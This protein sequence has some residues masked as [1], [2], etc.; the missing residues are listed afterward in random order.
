MQDSLTYISRI[1]FPPTRSPDMRP[2]VGTPGRK[3]TVSQTRC[4]CGCELTSE[5]DCDAKLVTEAPQVVSVWVERKKCLVSGER[6]WASDNWRETCVF[7]FDN[8]LLVDVS[9]LYKCRA[10]FIGGTPIQIFLCAHLEPL[11][12][13]SLWLLENPVFGPSIIDKSSRFFV[14]LTNAF[15]AVLAL[16]DFAFE[17]RCFQWGSHPDILTADGCVKMQVNQMTPKLAAASR[18]ETMVD[19][20]KSMVLTKLSLVSPV[21][22]GERVQFVLGDLE[23]KGRTPTWV[24]PANRFFER[25]IKTSRAV[26]ETTFTFKDGERAKLVDALN[27]KGEGGISLVD[28]MSMAD[29]KQVHIQVFDGS[30]GSSLQRKETFVEKF[31][32]LFENGEC[33][34]LFHGG[35]KGVAT[36]DMV[37]F[38][39]PAGVMVGSK[40]LATHE[41]PSD[42]VD[43]V[44]CMKV[45]PAFL[46]YDAA[47][48]LVPGLET[49]CPGLLENEGI[50]Q[51]DD[52]GNVI[53]PELAH[54]GNNLGESSKE[55]A[56]KTLDALYRDGVRVLSLFEVLVFT[57][58]WHLQHR[59]AVGGAAGGGGG[60]AA[61]GLVVG[62][63]G[64]V[65][66]GT[67]GGGEEG[68]IVTHARAAEFLRP[69]LVGLSGSRQAS[70]V[71][72]LPS[73]LDPKWI[74]EGDV[75]TGLRGYAKAKEEFVVDGLKPLTPEARKRAGNAVRGGHGFA[76]G[77]FS[78]KSLELRL[79]PNATPHE[80]TT[81]DKVAGYDA[82][83]H[84]T[85]YDGHDGAPFPR[86][87]RIG[88]DGHHESNH[89]EACQKKYSG[90]TVCI[91]IAGV[92]LTRH[93]SGHGV[94]AVYFRSINMTLPNFTY[95]L[96]VINE[97]QNAKYNGQF[98]SVLLGG[99]T[100]HTQSSLPACQRALW[101]CGRCFCDK[102]LVRVFDCLGKLD[103]VSLSSVLAL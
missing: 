79:A 30:S 10:Q 52:R 86:K 51:R 82:I 95:S 35:R 85:R 102:P 36:A 1:K 19:F 12:A 11:A 88:P 65:V 90:M 67:P 92:N 6:A 32:A 53:F 45:K 7:N 22:F 2:V 17:F 84:D 66:Q 68:G 100:D 83:F 55:A 50:L 76:R 96:C 97:L 72:S 43:F 57:Y 93:E 34:K 91:D 58:R 75:E 63:N 33:S 94:K 71:S 78:V 24:S 60:G 21:F 44:R 87:M 40:V 69:V 81:D 16:T 23:A 5:A 25:G 61:G 3:F 8:K 31:R 62:A 98:L 99:V 77:V 14:Q 27:A 38:F 70:N 13:N 56:T 47:C 64:W 42:V 101:T 103:L 18:P 15:M 49:Y 59:Q 39:T 80:T 26:V 4:T 48:K 37:C 46:C 28:D 89:D 29:L 73:W 9:L 41:S 20:D 54:V 74:T